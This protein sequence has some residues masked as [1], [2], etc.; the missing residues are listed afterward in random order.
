MA[1]EDDIVST[2]RRVFPHDKD[3]RSYATKCMMLFKHFLPSVKCANLQSFMRYFH[4]RIRANYTELNT[5]S[6]IFTDMRKLAEQKRP[7]CSQMCRAV[8]AVS[9]PERERMRRKSSKRIEHNNTHVINFTEQQIREVIDKLRKSDDDVDTILMLMLQSGLRIIEVLQLA[10]VTPAKSNSDKHYALFTN[11]AKTKN[12]QQASKTVEKPLLFTESDEFIENL[13]RVRAYVKK[14]LGAQ[15]KSMTNKQITNKFNHSVN[16]RVQKHLGGSYTSHIARKI[17]GSL[18]YKLFGSKDLSLN[19]WLEK[20]LG[21]TTIT[22][23]LSYSNVNV[24]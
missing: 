6:N 13:R 20:V 3:I 21:H 7:E 24:S 16:V 11:L 5:L 18:S 23:S 9:Q 4:E 14:S 22:S 1:E 2:F 15:H 17:Y 12:K 8:L 10:Q 19:A